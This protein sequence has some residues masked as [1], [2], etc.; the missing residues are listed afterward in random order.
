MVINF[1]ARGISR[2]AHKLARTPTLIEA[3]KSWDKKNTLVVYVRTTVF[4]T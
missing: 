1:R 2:G 4:F 3:K